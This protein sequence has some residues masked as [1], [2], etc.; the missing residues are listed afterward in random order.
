MT[1]KR[2]ILS[3]LTTLLIASIVIFAVLEVA[4]G[5]VAR[6]MMGVDAD[7]AAVAALREELGLGGNPI[8][9]YGAWLANM[10]RGDLGVSYTYRVPVSQLIGERLAIS[11]PLAAL[12]FIISTGLAVCGAVASVRARGRIGEKVILGLANLGLAVPN[13]WLA[14]MLMLVFAV[15]LQWVPAGGFPGWANPFAAISALALPALALGLPQG[16][17]MLRVLRASLLDVLG[18][19]FM[20]T[21]RAKGLTQPEALWRH[22][23]PNAVVP[24][25]PILGLQFAFL[26]AGA[27][28]VENVFYLPG[29]GRL[30][31]QAITQRD[32]ITVK[33]ISMMMV[34]A[35]VLISFLVD[36]LAAR[37]D[38]RLRTGPRA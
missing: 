35:V 4:P 12:A 24:V 19:D 16:A 5:D 27:V 11:L 14:L 37:L 22:G 2:R 9:R 25:L 30:V 15:A 3:L 38:P 17:I 26:I 7:P 10:A 1:L 20:R 29:L 28:I 36:L 8:A 23:L 34:F 18:Q 21:A 33:A 31:L 6:F 32:L 13:F